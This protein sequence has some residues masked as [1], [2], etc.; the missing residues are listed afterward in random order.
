MES[1]VN[2]STINVSVAENVPTVRCFRWSYYSPLVPGVTLLS[3]VLAAIVLGVAGS[4]GFGPGVA[5]SGGGGSGV[6][7]PAFATTVTLA[8]Q[9]PSVPVMQKNDQPKPPVFSG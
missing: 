7:P 1:N 4:S 2:T 3:F 8:P 6:V 5:A 9:P